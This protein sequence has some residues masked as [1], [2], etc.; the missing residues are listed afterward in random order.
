MAKIDRSEQEKTFQIGPWK[1][2]MGTICILG[3]VVI[4]LGSSLGY[5]ASQIGQPQNPNPQENENLIQAQVV[6][7]F[8]VNDTVEKVASVDQGQTAFDILKK[9]ADIT[10]DN[11]TNGKVVTGITYKNLTASNTNT[12][13][14]AFYINGRLNLLG[15]ERHTIRNGDQIVL[16]YERK[17][18]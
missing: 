6:I 3:L 16:K 13:Q 17:P 2:K 14:W 7:I 4:M 18:F 12:E 15:V 5:I 11:T 8:D 9:V 1:L 10:T